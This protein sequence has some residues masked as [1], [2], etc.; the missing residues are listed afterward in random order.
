MIEDSRIF[1]RRTIYATRS[2]RKDLCDG[3]EGVAVSAPRSAKL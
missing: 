3:W 2:L 1:E